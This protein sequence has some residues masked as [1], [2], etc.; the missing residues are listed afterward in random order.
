MT[1]FLGAFNPVA[2]SAQQLILTDGICNNHSMKFGMV[3]F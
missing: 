2:I 1:P 3:V